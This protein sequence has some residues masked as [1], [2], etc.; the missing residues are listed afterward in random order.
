MKKIKTKLIFSGFILLIFG[1]LVY[2]ET[3]LPFF[4]KFLPIG[5]NKLIIVILNINLLLI[6]LL[7]FLV[8]RTLVKTYIE[9]KRGIWGA[10]L[11]TKLTITLVLISIIPSFT[12]YVL[13][14]GFFQISMDKWFGQKIEDTLDDALEFSRF[15]YEDLFQRHERVGAI[16]ANEIKKKRLLDDPKGL[17]AYVQKNTTSR[18]PEYFTIYDDSGHLLQSARRLTPEIEKKFSALARSSLKDNKIRA[19]EPLKKGELILSGLQIANE[20]GEFRAMLFIGEEIEI[21]GT[22][23]MQEI[24]IAS[25]E[26]QKSRP[27]KKLLKWSFYIPLTLVTLMTVFFSVWVGIKMATEIVTPIEK[28][29]EGVSTIAKGSFDLINLE[30]KSQD[31]IGT[32][33]MAFNAM[34]KDLKIAKDEIE[35]RRRY[36]EIILDNVA[37]GIISTDKIGTIQFI[38]K[39]AQKI[40]GIENEP[41]AGAS[42]KNI[43]GDDFKKH[44]KFF[45]KEAREVRHGSVTREMRLN[46]KND[47]KYI[48]ASLTTL[49][50]QARKTEGFV[51]AFDDITYIVRAERLATWREAA[52]KLTHE[53]KNPLTPIMLSAERIRRRLLPNSHDQEKEVLENTTSVII[54]S[55]NDIKGIVNE[56]TKLTH[57]VQSKTM[58][59]LNSIVDETVLLY[60][61]LYQN[62]TL[63]CEKNALPPFLVDRDG[64][65]RAI[66]NI[67]TNS[68][69][70]IGN[71]RGAIKITTRHDSDKGFNI[72]EIA[73][74][75]KGIPNEEKSKIFD[76]YFTKDANGMGLGLA[77]VHSIILEHHGRIHVEDNYPRG[78]KFIIELPTIE[79]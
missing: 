51:I 68:I 52:K 69:K 15:Y 60:E 9:Q 25:R 34:A 12:L 62:L 56:L 64:L 13:S 10:R 70:A 58:E 38:N 66:I 20:T 33:V 11:K 48:R 5:E 49:K 57:S 27:F 7:L 50:D 21:A 41:W 26:L 55:V 47:V 65:K 61:H 37:T 4:K 1:V 16:I 73:D 14:G 67:I 54:Q 74:T 76:P 45:L 72:I 42:L 8:S 43:L 39:A 22:K 30:D 78:T 18:I 31:E 53:I 29:K 59:D 36:M 3:N 28:V 32:L 17:A 40:L 35:E 71:N 46:L 24:A 6:L 19:I 2:L 75:G 23:S 79:A 63:T 44:M 77:I